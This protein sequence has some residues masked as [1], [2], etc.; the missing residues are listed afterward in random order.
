[1]KL[2]GEKIREARMAQGLTQVQLAKLTGEKT[3]T[4]INNWESGTSRPSIDK[5]PR[6]CQALQITPD[7]LFN[8]SGEYPSI[9]EMAMIRKYRVLDT[10]G[11]NA[12][13][14]VLDI[15]HDRMISYHPKKQRVKI[16]SSSISGRMTGSGHLPRSHRASVV[17]NSRSQSSFST[18]FSR[19]SQSSMLRDLLELESGGMLHR[20]MV[21]SPPT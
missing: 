2:I 19:A 16:R 4:V 7:A 12:V 14:S 3:G 11:K 15:E 20:I 17:T 9:G 10:F 21:A 1:M 5:I 18:C 6:L 13:D 8:I